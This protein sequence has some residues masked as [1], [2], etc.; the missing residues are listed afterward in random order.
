MFGMGGS[1]GRCG[2]NPGCSGGAAAGREKG[3]VGWRV[4][5]QPH[6]S[7]CGEGEERGTG[8]PSSSC[9]LHG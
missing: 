8:V 4:L 3:E 9:S 5:S 7:L 1:A 2:Q 6:K